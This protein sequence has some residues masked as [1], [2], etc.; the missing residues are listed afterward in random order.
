M[1]PGPDDDWSEISVI[2]HKERLS[3]PDRQF[4]S[5]GAAYQYFGDRLPST[6]G[7][8]RVTPEQDV[9]LDVGKDP[10]MEEHLLRGIMESAGID[11]EPQ[12]PSGD[13][14]DPAP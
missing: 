12:S 5:T 4:N 3:S 7:L 9:W 6:Q 1:I 13:D 11:T 8:V 2:V 14:R 10:A